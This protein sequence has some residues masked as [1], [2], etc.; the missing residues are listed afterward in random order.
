MAD[1]F[2][3]QD[4]GGYRITVEWGTGPYTIN[5][6]YYD[7]GKDD[8]SI[9]V[10]SDE[11]WDGHGPFTL[12]WTE[13]WPDAIRLGLL[14][15]AYLMVFSLLGKVAGYRYA[16]GE[17]VSSIRQQLLS[18]EKEL[19][20]P[21]VFACDPANPQLPEHAVLLATEY[22]C[23]A[24]RIRDALVILPPGGSFDRY[25]R[26][27]E[28]FGES[29]LTLRSTVRWPATKFGYTMQLVGGKPPTLKTRSLFGKSARY[30]TDPHQAN[31]HGVVAY[32]DPDMVAVLPVSGPSG[33][34]RRRT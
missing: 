3:A 25:R 24:V 8:I 7:I 11:V 29:P 30:R 21:L 15:S 28:A 6:K 20:R 4:D 31:Q 27:A 19:A 26:L 13:P 22:Q 5:P 2:Q 9:R 23:W 16:Q 10:P 32:S 1:Y 14:K 12:R 33:N 34:P 18:P 17:A